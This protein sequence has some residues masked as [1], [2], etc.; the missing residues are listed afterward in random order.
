MDYPQQHIKPYDEEGKKTEQVERM[1]DNIAEPYLI[2]RYRPQ[3]AQKSDCLVTPFPT[4]AY[5]GCSYRHR[6]FCYPRLS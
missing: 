2:S 3:L 5:D 1:F 4:A 6:R